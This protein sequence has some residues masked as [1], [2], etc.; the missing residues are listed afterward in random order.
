MAAALVMIRKFQSTRPRGRTRRPPSVNRDR[1]NVSIH[2]SSRE[3]A[4]IIYNLMRCLMSFNPRVLA[5]GRD[6][7][8]FFKPDFLESFN[9]RVLAG[10]RD[11]RIMSSAVVPTPVSI[12]ASSREDATMF[13]LCN[14]GSRQFQSTRPRGRTRL[15]IVAALPR[16][17]VS[18]HASS[19]EDATRKPGQ[20]GEA[21]WF[22]STRP[23]GRTR[24]VSGSMQFQIRCYNPRVLAGGRDGEN[25]RHDA[26]V[27][28]SI[29]ASSREDATLY[30]ELHKHNFRFNPRVL[31][32]GRD[33]LTKGCE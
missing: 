8:I 16:L 15:Y 20:T 18:I 1:S 3:D 28:V 11:A 13:S 24:H 14:S 9:P 26:Q 30:S 32:G 5:G 12:H 33:G 10:G 7:K 31:A 23:R 25:R 17:L 6:D 29:H 21:E 2:A 19:R 27:V 22:Q 4:T